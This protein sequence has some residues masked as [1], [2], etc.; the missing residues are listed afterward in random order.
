[1]NGTTAKDGSS[2]KCSGQVMTEYAVVLVTFLVI[3][4]MLVFLLAVF[5]ETGWRMVS[6]ISVDL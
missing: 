6:L 4:L 5:T 1:M 2:R 3:M